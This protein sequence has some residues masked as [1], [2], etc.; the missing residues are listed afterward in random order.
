MSGS[1]SQA[2]IDALTQGE[3]ISGKGN[4]TF[5]SLVETSVVAYERLPMLD[6]VFERL[7]R[8]LSINFRQFFSD[9]VDVTVVDTSSLRFGSFIE[10]IK[11]PALLSVF[12]VEEWKEPAIINMHSNFVFLLVDLLLGGRRGEKSELTTMRPY[13]IVEKGI[14][15]KIIEVILKEFSVA[16]KPVEEIYF[17][18][19]C[20]ESNPKFGMVVLPNNAAVKCTFCIESAKRKGFFDIVFPYSTLEPVREKLLQSFMGEKFGED[21]IWETHLGNEVWETSV[22]TDIILDC[23]DVKLSEML[24]WKVGSIIEL[25]ADSESKVTI[26]AGKK[27]LYWGSMGNIKGYIAIQIEK[28]Y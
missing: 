4:S 26:R 14:C 25:D 16:F 24:N 27:E 8:L 5:N 17:K 10:S 11:E 21:T 15:K 19:D 9:I 2:E 3:S 13:T 7:M 22:E 23:M 28:I 6:V 20:V 12:N 18:L 1:L